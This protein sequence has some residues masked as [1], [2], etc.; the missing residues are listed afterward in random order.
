MPC[1]GVDPDV[2]LVADASGDAC[3]QRVFAGGS[4][5]IQRDADGAERVDRADCD[6]PVTYLAACDHIAVLTNKLPGELAFADRFGTI[7][8]DTHLGGKD[9]RIRIS[10]FRQA[11]QEDDR[12]A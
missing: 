11:C 3:L 2:P 10:A 1:G 8:V 6:L 4:D 9:F 5:L 12:G 7:L